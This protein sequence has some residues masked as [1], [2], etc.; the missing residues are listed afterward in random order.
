M[1]PLSSSQIIRMMNIVFGKQVS[2]NMFH[3]VLLTNYYKDILK[4]AE[5]RNV[6][7]ETGHDMSTALGYVK[8]E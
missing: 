2:A 4:L 8:K 6:V 3:N 5:T 7:S 1:N